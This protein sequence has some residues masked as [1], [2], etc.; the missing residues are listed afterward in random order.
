MM[1][2]LFF[3][4]SFVLG[5]SMASMPGDVWQ[6]EINGPIGPAT[7]DY[8]VRSMEDAQN[9][10]AEVIILRMDTPGGLDQ[11]MREII[12]TILASRV[13]VVGYVGPQGSRAASAGTY[14]LYASHIAAMAPATN[15]GAATPVMIGGAP[16]LPG[17]QPEE[18]QQGKDTNEEKADTLRTTE[19]TL[20]SKVVNDAQAYI[21]SLAELRGRNAEWAVRA[22][23]EAATLTAEEALELNVIDLI[24]E[25]TPALVE[26]LHG[27][28]VAWDGE[29]Q[30]LDTADANLHEVEPGWRTDFLRVITNPSVA[31]ILL[32]LGIY[33]LI[34]EFSSPGMGAGG[35]IGGICLLTALYALQLLPISYSA[36]ALMLL[37]LVLMAAEGFS[38]SFGALGLGGI[39]A[40]LLGSIM[41]MDTN[42]PGFRIALPIILAL[43]TVSALMLLL[44]LSMIV[45][46]RKQP[47]VSGSA[48]LVG[49]T[50]EVVD[51][52][53][54]EIRVRLNGEFWR[55]QSP[56]ALQPGDRVTVNQVSGLVLDV[57][58]KE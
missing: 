4:M 50:A 18:T 29:T 7:S 28:E 34:F 54:G 19:D 38:P 33:G 46:A 17:S 30:I 13:P 35:I 23:T 55:V 48:A 26:A 6:L 53:D 39:A 22:V 43:T 3:L 20:K 1:P 56:G 15:L 16:T 2:K 24:A 44:V 11:A 52:G 12:Q 31:Y 57:K 58:K 49:E 37:G 42:V 47:V 36:L 8:I 10:A 21:R 14:I 51:T 32:L 25:N 5:S 41:L 45:R 9:S 40:F 27:R